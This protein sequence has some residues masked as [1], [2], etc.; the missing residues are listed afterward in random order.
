MYAKK[1]ILIFFIL[2]TTL[3]S[4][5]KDKVNLQLD[6][7]HQF[8]FAGYYIAKEKG[9]YNENNLDVTIKEF[10]YS[11]N[12][13]QNVLNKKAQYS[14][15]KSSLIIDKLQ[16]KDI[17]LLAAIYQ[18]S[19]MVLIS[20]DK[21]IKTLKD[22]KGKKVMLT[23]DARS[24]A[25]IN[26]M[27]KSKNI[28]LN[29]IDFIEHSF[30]LED[31]INGKTKAMGCYLS[32]EPYSLMKEN[33][34][35]KVFDPKDYGFDFYGGL[36]FTSKEELKDNPQRVKSFYDASIRGWK[37]AFENIEETA[38]IIYDKYNT[39]NKTLEAL[40]FEGKVLKELSKYEEGL[41]GNIDS[42]KIDEIKRL[43]LVLGFVSK[44]NFKI[45]DIIF[46]KNEILFNNEEKNFLKDKKISLLSSGL[47]MPFS[48]KNDNYLEGIEIEFWNLLNKKLNSDFSITQKESK[49]GL[50]NVY[51]K[52]NYNLNE[53]DKKND[54][55]SKPITKVSMAIATKNDKNFI[56]DLSILKNEKIAILKNSDLYITLK[57]KYPNIKFVQANNTKE[58]FAL[59]E[60]DKVFGV[61][62]NILTLSH[63]IIKNK[64]NDIK[65]TNSLPYEL[66]LRLVTKKEN[67]IFIDILNKIIDQISIKEKETISQKYQLILYQQ[68]TDFSWIYKFVLP[69]I[70]LLIIITV[71]NTR[72]RHE[73]KKRKV[74]EK[75]LLEYANKDSL[76]KV[77]NRRKIEVILSSQIREAK[78]TNSVFSIIF[79]DIDNFKLVN[80]EFGH[81]KGDR[82]LI[83]MSTLVSNNI[84]KTDFLG[85]W[86]GE[87]FIII[88]PNTTSQEA[89]KIANNLR[90]L[91]S[92]SNFN[93]KKTITSSFGITQYKKND[94]KKEIVKRADEAMYYVKN[95][96]K[97]A[98]KID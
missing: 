9:Y 8:Q 35:F 40:I 81:V 47:N 87:E 54:V 39:Q 34:K 69:L 18:N 56:L 28:K 55:I 1:I 13:V 44:K 59:L 19:P 3:Y 92:Q 79:F 61:I 24:A 65:V 25:S 86:G 73:I 20:L 80:D 27:I 82:V 16:G 66:N 97:N 36:L 29:E 33:I 78:K 4:S 14:V 51:V 23:P 90:D 48:F 30:K 17:V 71:T 74:A 37:Y 21:N 75:A 5:K 85:R 10:E 89:F 6:W 58:A 57:S 93:I 32:N 49:D 67:E 42:K 31:L 64:Y 70:I 68:V 50:E 98:V 38:Q 91:I 72:M 22:L 76:T 2:I 7:L 26:S 45:D 88:L 60:D 53:I 95:N 43:Y 84:R 12:L 63:H 46:D 96:G 77:F 94:T 83:T 62:D 11:T 15:G 52:F 41:L